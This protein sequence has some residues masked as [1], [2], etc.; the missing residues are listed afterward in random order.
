MGDS[1]LDGGTRLSVA[2]TKGLEVLGSPV[3]PV[4]HVGERLCVAQLC[5]D[6]LVEEGDAVFGLVVLLEEVGGV[7]L[8][9]LE[10]SIGCLLR[11]FHEVQVVVRV[12]SVTVD[13]ALGDHLAH[14]LGFAFG[15]D[16]KGI[17]WVEGVGCLCGLGPWSVIGEAGRAQV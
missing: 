15:L 2:V 3:C 11:P 6:L 17:V 7:N 1:Q 5:L 10:K 13:K 9:V 4:H 16:D 12:W 8:E 14:G